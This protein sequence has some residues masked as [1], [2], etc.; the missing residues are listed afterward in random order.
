MQEC[1]KIS[2]QAVFQNYLFYPH[3]LYKIRVQRR[4]LVLV[5]SKV[6]VRRATEIIVT[7]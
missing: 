5:S 3:K 6:I 4:G 2:W 1:L 7:F